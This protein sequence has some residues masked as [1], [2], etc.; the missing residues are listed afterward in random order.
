MPAEPASQ[1]LVPKRARA[2]KTNARP[3][4]IKPASDSIASFSA[5]VSV[6]RSGLDISSPLT[7]TS[8]SETGGM[9]GAGA[10]ASPGCAD[11]RDIDL[12]LRAQLR[13]ASMQLRTLLKF[14]DVCT[15]TKST[16]SA[17]TAGAGTLVTELIELRI[18]RQKNYGRAS[19]RAACNKLRILERFLPDFAQSRVEA[20]Q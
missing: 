8:S 19:A 11:S 14:A 7:T 9:C 5:L 6:S 16:Y 12:N 15:S 17:R 1:S 13:G 18:N 20:R 10:A 3:P 2:L 4:D